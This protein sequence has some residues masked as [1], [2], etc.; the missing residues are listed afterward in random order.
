MGAVSNQF[1]NEPAGC[2]ELAGWKTTH[3]SGARPYERASRQPQHCGRLAC[4]NSRN[5]GEFQA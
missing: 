5:P 1:K 3:E 2:R 4:Y